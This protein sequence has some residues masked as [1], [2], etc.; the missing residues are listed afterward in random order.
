MCA[1]TR[2]RSEL[3]PFQSS[4]GQSGLKHRRDKP[5]KSW[6]LERVTGDRG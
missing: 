3:H 5:W 4:K 6:C 1:T 2:L